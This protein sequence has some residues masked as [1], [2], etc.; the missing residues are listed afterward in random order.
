MIQGKT[1]PLNWVKVTNLFI[2][3]KINLGTKK[4]PSINF[5][6]KFKGWEYYLDFFWA[7]SHWQGDKPWLE[8][9]HPKCKDI[10]G[11][12][13]GWRRLGITFGKM[14]PIY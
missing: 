6:Q 1:C 5:T 2:K 11:W 7:T 10:K 14:L 3:M 8:E 12:R 4:H 13:F 9:V